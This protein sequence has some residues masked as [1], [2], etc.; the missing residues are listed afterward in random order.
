[1]RMMGKTKTI[2]NGIGLNDDDRS[3]YDNV[4]IGE[5]T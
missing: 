1:M 5:T 4:T 3:H 2:L